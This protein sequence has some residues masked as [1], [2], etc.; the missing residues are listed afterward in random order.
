MKVDTA[1]Q[2]GCVDT[3]NQKE[4]LTALLARAQ[5]ARK[6]FQKSC[7]AYLAALDARPDLVDDWSKPMEKELRTD[8]TKEMGPCAVDS[9]QPIYVYAK[10]S[11]RFTGLGCP[12]WEGRVITG[13][14][15]DP[16]RAPVTHFF[17]RNV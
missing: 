16:S 11:I 3:V 13:L 14:G 6:R 4:R 10:T 2:K 1:D 17:V 9:N 12:M 7:Y 8:L 15:G 5:R